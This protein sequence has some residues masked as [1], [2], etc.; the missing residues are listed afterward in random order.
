MPL[1]EAPQE[2]EDSVVA[3]QSVRHSSLPSP[4]CL[5]ATVRSQLSFAAA[6][7]RRSLA[8]RTCFDR[9][10]PCIA[11]N[12]FFSLFDF[13]SD[14]RTWCLL[15]TRALDPRSGG[16][17]ATSSLLKRAGT[18][19]SLTTSFDFFTA[20]TTLQATRATCPSGGNVQL[21]HPLHPVPSTCPLA[22]ASPPVQQQQSPRHLPLPFP[23]L[24]PHPSLPNYLANLS[25][26][27]MFSSL[28][29]FP[30]LH[31]IPR[32][33]CSRF[34]TFAPIDGYSSPCR[35]R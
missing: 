26:Q 18:L 2:E 27:I 14:S 12:V 34:D 35:K 31:R 30:R 15:F 3:F 5:A 6:K 8:A 29:P 9:A 7:V 10:S 20:L 24:V 28:S 13:L 19:L 22:F 33:C 16:V 32:T 25:R 21:L 1:D 23:Q 17:R 11:S 4:H